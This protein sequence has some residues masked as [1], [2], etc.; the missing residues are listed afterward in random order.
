M[1]RTRSRRQAEQPTAEVAISGELFAPVSPGIELCYQTFGEPEA[2]PLLLVMGLGG[3]MT[4]WPEDLCNQLARAGFYVIRYDNR[5]TGRSTRMQGRV[6]RPMVVQA[7]L[8]RRSAASRVQPE[9]T[10][11]CERYVR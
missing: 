3:P 4:W 11:I 2:D 1:P 6:T 10:W 5:D 7:F 9:F 8:G